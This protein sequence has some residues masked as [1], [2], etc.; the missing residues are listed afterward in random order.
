MKQERGCRWGWWGRWGW[1]HIVRDLT[2]PTDVPSSK[3]LYLKWHCKYYQYTKAKSQPTVW[4][5]VFTLIF[6][7]NFLLFVNAFIP[8]TGLHEYSTGGT[9]L[10]TML[11]YSILPSSFTAVFLERCLCKIL[12]KSILKYYEIKIINVFLI[13]YIIYQILNIHLQFW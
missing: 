4:Y 11:S 9:F 10:S 8:K 12:I 1:F 6:I 13:I 2:E 5:M 7:H 3:I